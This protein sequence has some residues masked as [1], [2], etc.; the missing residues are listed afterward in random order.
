MRFLLFAFALCSACSA[1]RAGGSGNGAQGP[2]PP[3]SPPPQ[4]CLS[5]TACEAN[6]D[7]TALA[8]SR[9]NTSLRAPLCQIIRCSAEGSQCSEDA[10]CPDGMSCLGG[11]CGTCASVPENATCVNGQPRCLGAD[12]TV[13]GSSCVNTTTDP[14]HCG[15][16]YAAVPV[17]ADC[18]GGEIQCHDGYTLCGAHCVDLSNDIHHCGECFRPAMGAFCDN[19]SADCIEGYESLC[20]GQCLVTADDIDN[21]GGCALSCQFLNDIECAR[22]SV[23]S[24]SGPSCHDSSCR[25]SVSGVTGR[26]W[27]DTCEAMGGRCVSVSYRFSSMIPSCSSHSGD[28]VICAFDGRAVE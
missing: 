8:G 18:V 24:S 26:S 6:T 4:S 17:N 25:I 10:L 9:C 15:S 27:N 13:C 23:C 28:D 12:K 3:P 14:D 1:S 16:C 21:C 20:D 11:R 2:T 22:S 19:G 5:A 7:C